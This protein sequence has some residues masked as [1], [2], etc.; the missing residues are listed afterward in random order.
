MPNPPIS[1]QEQRQQKRE[2]FCLEVYQRACALLAYEGPMSNEE[3][4][5]YMNAAALRI[6]TG[7]SFKLAQDLAERDLREAV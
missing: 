5:F 7:V 2:E 3:W 1:K 6:I 4:A